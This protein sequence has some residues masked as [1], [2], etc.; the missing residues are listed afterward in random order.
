MDRTKKY[1][2]ESGNPI[3]KEH[4]WDTLTDK[5]IL[6]QKLQIAKIK[7]TDYMKPK[8]KE[9]SVDTSVLLRRGNKIPMGRDTETKFRAE[10]EGK[11][12]QR[13]PHLGI[14]PIYS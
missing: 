12:I 8:K 13:L 7:F 4:T 9:Q 3:I 11:A 10:T 1:H 5:S 2:P 14:Y 6:A